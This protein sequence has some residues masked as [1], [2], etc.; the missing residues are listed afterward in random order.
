M[1]NSGI[2][3]KNFTKNYGQQ[4]VI[5]I[6][7]ALFKPGLY[8]IKGENGSGK[9]TLF[10]SLAGLLPFTGSIAF[11]DGVN[12]KDNPVEY[13]RRVN[14]SEAE[15]LYPGFLTAHDLFRFVGK[16]K[17]VGIDQQDS[18]VNAFGMSHYFRSPCQTFSSGMQKK[19]SLAMAFLGN[20]KLLILDEPLIT[21]DSKAR[22]VLWQHVGEALANHAIVLISSHQLL[23]ETEHALQGTF[24][25]QDRQ[26]IPV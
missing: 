3:I 17:G 20:P 4:A 16:A 15:P 23:E 13:R 21:L 25:I 26:L 19:L 12:L 18:L 9:S 24:I 8:W 11:E 14:Y 2:V 6:P 10:R 1:E 22:V 7:D 5:T